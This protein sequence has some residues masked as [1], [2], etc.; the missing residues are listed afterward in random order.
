MKNTGGSAFPDYE[1]F[2]LL[3]RA[4][5]KPEYKEI[6]Y[7]ASRGMTLRD[8]FIAHAPAEPQPWFSPA[9]ETERPPNRFV[10]YPPSKMEYASARD[11][12]NAAGDDGWHN[13]NE[14]AQGEWDKEKA[15][16]HYVQWPAA[17]ADAMLEARKK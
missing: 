7:T 1:R 13:P 11:A 17:W 2:E 12:D 5:L 9:M 10:G 14:Q 4:D 16:Q 8:Y 3:R 6:I 15:K